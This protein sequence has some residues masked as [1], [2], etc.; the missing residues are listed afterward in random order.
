MLPEGEPQYGPPAPLTVALIGGPKLHFEHPLVYRVQENALE[1]WES[2]GCS[3]FPLTS[4]LYWRS[5]HRQREA[6][7]ARPLADRPQA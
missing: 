4:V 6:Y 2:T 7:G 3:R 1:V 5:E